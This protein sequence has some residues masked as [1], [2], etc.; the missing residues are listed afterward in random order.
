MRAI[1]GDS[2]LTI[3]LEGDIVSA[4]AA[5]AEAEIRRLIAE[6]PGLPVCL[7]A[8]DLRRISSAGLRV[9][10]KLSKALPQPPVIRNVSADVYDTFEVTGFT[11]LIDIRRK[12]RELSIEGCEI[13]G[14]GAKGTV[15]RLDED[16]V[17]KVF[18][19]GEEELPDIESE[20]N[21]AKGAFLA[22]VPTAIPF[23]IVRVGDHYGTV[24]EMVDARNCNDVIKAEPERLEEIIEQFAAFLH[25]LH[26]LKAEPGQLT[27]T[28]DVFL[29]YVDIAAP[30]LPAPL[31]ERLRALLRAM[32]AELGLLHGDMHL[33]NVMLSDGQMMLIDMD[34][35]SAGNPVFE[36]GGLY[37]AY[38]AFCEGDSNNTMQFFG[39]DRETAA[40]I[41]KKSLELYLGSPDA[42][43]LRAVWKKIQI[44]GYLRY[45]Y[46]L[47][48]ELAERVQPDD[49]RVRQAV[50]SLEELVKEVDE[51]AM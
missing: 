3:F 42:D 39:I 8:G 14:T 29:G 37:A 40:H 12:P 33:K 9:L 47:M 35:L 24:Y 51:L 13:I 21:K 22:G 16:T 4:N 30:A 15:Y 17:V 1:T 5:D 43:T 46:I 48:A 31:A 19:G 45:I 10:L 38:I 2:K 6:H 20:Q 41:V 34:S 36:F 18:H 28:R 32:P 11:S 44:A 49:F 7:D 50:Q 25:T 23:D 26:G 27:G